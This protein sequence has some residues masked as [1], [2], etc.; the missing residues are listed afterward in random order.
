[1]K[2]YNTL[3]RIKDE[4]KPL[5]GNTVKMYACGPTVYDYAHI[6]NLR[7]YLNEDFLRRYLEYTGYEIDEVMNITDI[8]DKIIK[9]A[10]ELKVD[11][12]EITKKY[13]EAF[14]ADLELLNIEKPERMPRATE[15]IESM[16]SL[17]QTLLDKEIAY[18]SD[19]GSIYFSVNKFKDYG[20]LAHLD[21][22][23]LKDGA[24]I[25]N[26][27]Y[28][29]E[30][31]QDFVLWKAK[32]E[33]EPSWLA[34]F[35]EGRPGW[36]IECSAMSMKYLGETLDLHAG[37]V[38]L[39]F[40]HHENEI[41]QSEAATGKQFVNYWFHPEHLMVNGQKMSKSLGNIFTINDVCEKYKVEPLD[42]RMLC[43]MSHYREKMN[44]TDESIIS[45]QNT[46]NNLRD[47]L[48]RLQ[49]I[50]L[51]GDKTDADKLI[52]KA[53]S[54]F[55][56]SLDDDLNMPR[57]M[58]VLFDF[59]KEV[60]KLVTQGLTKQEA[61]EVQNLLFDFDRVLG[62]ELNKVCA[63]SGNDDVDNLLVVRNAA[64][65]NKD[66][67]KSDSVRDEIRKLGFEVEDTPGGQILKKI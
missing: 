21:F 50:D 53:E 17:V 55:K 57:A 49:Q 65:T 14:L 64:R 41:A 30:N 26:D 1:M 12:H 18:K 39:I 19:D 59:T 23:G 54:A 28:D 33:G 7:T 3:T 35:G 29:K 37:A 61:E 25:D 43:L 34:P 40:P 27:E 38:D 56:C 58:S 42:F 16:I 15:E 47:F 67:A 36:H 48:I 31:A 4:F 10:N 22:S 20:K 5:S 2:L 66:W 60:N 32:K 11:Y 45:A 13:E 46:L 51:E 6:G 8:E 52:N 24:R 9:R 62:L 63:I 44:F